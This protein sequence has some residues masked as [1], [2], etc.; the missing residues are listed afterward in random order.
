MRFHANLPIELWRECVLTAVYLINRTPS[1][2][3]ENETPYERLYKKK[4]AYEHLKV[5]GSLC[6]THNQFCGGD[7]F[8]ERSK[9]CVFIGYPYG[10]KAWCVF[11]LDKH[12]FFYFQRCCILRN[13]ISIRFNF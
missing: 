7:K 2:V 6:Y 1:S 10:E 11:D 3:L 12:D 13:E 5:F 9:H 4:P 8:E